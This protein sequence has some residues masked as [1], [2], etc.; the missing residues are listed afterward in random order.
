M[1]VQS[2]ACAELNRRGLSYT[3]IGQFLGV[4]KQAV[5]RYFDGSAEPELNTKLRA[6]AMLGIPVAWWTSRAPEPVPHV[7][8]SHPA[9]VVVPPL[10][11]VLPPWPGREPEA[12]N[13]VALDLDDPESLE[14]ELKA[15]VARAHRA[16]HKA[17]STGDPKHA[18]AAEE[19]LRKAVVALRK[20]QGELSA[21]DMTRM[22]KSPQ[23]RDWLGRL[24]REIKQDTKHGEQAL[25]VVLDALNRVAGL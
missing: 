17:E 4:S 23:F 15:A 7:V 9:P 12:D 20:V 25:R 18:R 11:P 2:E 1:I 13:Y 10:P 3:Q 19:N 16:V 6:L 22:A 24:T 21:A 5:N 14:R 8:T